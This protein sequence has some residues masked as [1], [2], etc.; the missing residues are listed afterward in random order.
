M[1][2]RERN[3]RGPVKRDYSKK[4]IWEKKEKCA[5][6]KLSLAIERGSPLGGGDM[7]PF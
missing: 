5:C 3:G 4:K 7:Q 2:E 6:G 1:G